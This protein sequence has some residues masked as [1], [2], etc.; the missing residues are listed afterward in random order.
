MTKSKPN[1]ELSDKELGKVAGGKSQ[2]HPAA[3]LGDKVSELRKRSNA[4]AQGDDDDGG[5][6]RRPGDL[7]SARRR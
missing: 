5:K 3:R 4:A 1:Q 6:K 2:Q 7:G